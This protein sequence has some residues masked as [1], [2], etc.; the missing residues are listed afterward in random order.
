M[1]MGFFIS[2]RIGVKRLT[3]L[4]TWLAGSSVPLFLAMVQRFEEWRT[5]PESFAAPERA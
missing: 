5:A 1:I 4:L 2:E 3:G